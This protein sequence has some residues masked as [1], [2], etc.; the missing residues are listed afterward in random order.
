MSQ[1]PRHRRRQLEVTVMFEPHRQEGDLLQTAY[2]SVVAWP[3]R[4]LVAAQPSQAV[5]IGELSQRRERK[6]S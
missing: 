3:R 5:P 2:A 1:L 6:M 4:R